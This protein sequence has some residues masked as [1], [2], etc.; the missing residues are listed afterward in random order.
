MVGTGRNHISVGFYS[1]H[2]A[3]GE[4]GHYGKMIVPSADYRIFAGECSTCNRRWTCD[5]EILW[6]GAFGANLVGGDKLAGYREPSSA[7]VG[8]CGHTYHVAVGNS[9]SCGKLAFE[10]G[11]SVGINSHARQRESIN[12]AEQRLECALGV[13]E[14][15]CNLSAEVV[16]ADILQVADSYGKG[17]A[18][19][20]ITFEVGTHT[21]LASVGSDMNGRP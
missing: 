19:S 5:G 7:V 11:I 8:A 20:E 1:H 15:D 14:G 6:S 2:I 3:L 4:F 16:V 18:Y 21:H 12:G 10:V 13:K 17:S 9:H